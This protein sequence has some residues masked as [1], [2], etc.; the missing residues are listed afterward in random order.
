[1]KKISASKIM[2]TVIMAAIGLLFLLPFLWMLSTSFKPEA[3]VFTFPIEWIPRNWNA[4]EN[5]AEVW[6][7]NFVKYY[8]NSIYVTVATTVLNVSVCA[9]AAYGFS[10]V[11]FKGRDTMFLLVL[12]LYMVPPQASLVPQFLLFRSLHLFDSHLG[13]IL[14]NGF[15]VIGAFMLR[16]FFMG[17]SNEYIESAKIDGA[18]HARSFFQIALPLIR[19]AIATYAILRF[20]WTWNDYQ[21]PLIFLKSKELFTIQL[22]IRLFG[23]QYGDTYSLMMAGAVSAILPLVIIFIIGQKQVIEGIALGGVK[24]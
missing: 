6:S 17:V 23:D 19:P 7:G 13:L 12:A 4:M 5:Y 1:M 21:Y 9:L 3:D 20:I 16:Q 2:F 11:H 14:L 10:K 24:G 8:G 15:S 18:G 22:G